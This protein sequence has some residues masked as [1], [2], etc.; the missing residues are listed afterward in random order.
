[1]K[2]RISQLV[3]QAKAEACKMGNHYVGSE[4]LLLALMRQKDSA[5]TRYL[6]RHGVFYHQ[7]QEDLMVL[8]G[9]LDGVIK[10]EDV[11]MTQVAQEIMEEGRGQLKPFDLD[12]GD[13]DEI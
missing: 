9:I 2:E 1:M 7:V 4:H 11:Q 5:F 3:E 6:E 10:E 13:E 8:F 12:G